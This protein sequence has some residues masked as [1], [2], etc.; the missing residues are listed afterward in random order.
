MIKMVLFFGKELNNYLQTDFRKVRSERHDVLR[1]EAQVDGLKVLQ[2][3]KDHQRSDDEHYGY[4]KL[5]G[6]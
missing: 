3:I 5:E 2:L 4:C 1:I 6:E